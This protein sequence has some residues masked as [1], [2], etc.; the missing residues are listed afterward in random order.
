MIEAGLWYRPSYF[1]RKGETTWRQSCDREVG[2]V[3]KAVGVCDVSTLGKIDIQGP[4][5]A[6]LL[7][8]VYTGLFSTLKEGRVRYG[9]MLREDGTVMDDGTCAR[10]GPQHYV[11]T[12]TTAAAGD[13]M[14]HLEF[15]TQALHPEWSVTF[16]SVTE[17][18]AQFAVAGPQS[19]ALLNGLLDTAVDNEKWPFMSCGSVELM[20]VKGRLFRIS[21]SGEHAYEVAVP[22][23]YGAALFAELVKRAEALEGGAYGMEALN[24]LRIEKGHITHAEIHGR[25][26]AF[27]VGMQGMVSAK[28]DCIGKVMAARAGLTDPQRERMIGLRPVGVVKQLTAGAHI[29]NAGDDHVHRNDQGYVTSVCYS[30]DVGTMIGLGFVKNGPER[31]GERMVMRDHVRDLTAEVEICSPLFVDP[32]GGRLRG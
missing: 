12:T 10:M 32:E 3:R 15:V 25:V 17:Q 26:T 21:F 22:A 23:R 18:W 7:D 19:K 11:M 14:R 16:T 5:A 31:I 30:P 8:F 29:F 20:G 1:P 6:K 28:K 24:V 2:H 4:D 27:D 9:L 13:V